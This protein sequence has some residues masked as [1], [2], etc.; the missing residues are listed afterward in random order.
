MLRSTVNFRNGDFGSGGRISRFVCLLDRALLYL[1]EV[2]MHSECFA[3]VRFVT[4][5]VL[6][7]PVASKIRSKRNLCKSKVRHDNCQNPGLR[8]AGHAILALCI[9]VIG[10][11]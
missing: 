5:P 3:Q 8:Y 6:N 1:R 4:V 2:N 10:V 9:T 11:R 7:N